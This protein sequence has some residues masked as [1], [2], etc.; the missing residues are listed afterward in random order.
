MSDEVIVPPYHRID[1]A[2]GYRRSL[3]RGQSL[4]AQ[5]GA[6]YGLFYL[7]SGAVNLTRTTE[8]GNE[9]LIH[10]ARPVG[11]FAEASLFSTRYHCTA[12]ATAD[13]K[14]IEYKRSAVLELMNTDNG[15]ALAMLQRFAEQIQENRRRI[16]LMSIKSAEERILAAFGDKILNED[17]ASF[18]EVIG[19]APETVYRTLSKLSKNGKITKTSRGEYKLNCS[20]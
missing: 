19:F 4:F 7:L 6:T 14:L 12:T 9:V 3:E 15:F 10:K 8:S 2:D 18:S 17:I 1:K 11:T 5:G 20:T 13:S 16:E